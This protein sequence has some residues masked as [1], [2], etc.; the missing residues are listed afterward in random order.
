MYGPTD[1]LTAVG[2]PR[3]PRAAIIDIGGTAAKHL[4]FDC[5]LLRGH[6]D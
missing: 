3:R 5:T 1:A 2:S 6:R 4:L